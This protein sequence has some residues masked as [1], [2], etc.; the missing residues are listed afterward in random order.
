MF[1]TKH[2]SKQMTQATADIA[3][4]KIRAYVISQ[5]LGGNPD[6]YSSA[7]TISETMLM[8]LSPGMDRF[9]IAR[10]QVLT[11]LYASGTLEGI[12][13]GARHESLSAF[14]YSSIVEAFS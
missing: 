10:N 2:Q 12:E 14:V 13:R 8:R 3:F 9:D 4:G 11:H 6:Q 7:N 1:Q 5:G